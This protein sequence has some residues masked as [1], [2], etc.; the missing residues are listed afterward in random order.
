MGKKLKKKAPQK[1]KTSQRDS[2]S[3]RDDLPLCISNSLDLESTQ[4]EDEQEK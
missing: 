3:G 1:K 2:D 4:N